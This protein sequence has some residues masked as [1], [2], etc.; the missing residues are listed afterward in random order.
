LVGGD[1]VDGVGRLA[2][3]VDDDV[4]HEGTVEEG[5]MPRLRD[6]QKLP[7]LV[8]HELWTSAHLICCFTEGPVE[9]DEEGMRF[10]RSGWSWRFGTGNTAPE[11]FDSIEDVSEHISS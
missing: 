7:I 1:I 8:R 6:E 10:A 9:G 3:R 5:L 2:A 11:T 4:G